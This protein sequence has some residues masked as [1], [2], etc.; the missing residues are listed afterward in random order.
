M[1]MHSL[2][3]FKKIAWRY[4]N[5]KKAF[6]QASSAVK[7]SPYNNIMSGVL[8]NSLTSCNFSQFW[9]SVPVVME[10]TVSNKR[11]DERNESGAK[12]LR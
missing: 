6:P 9:L 4:V 10:R 11:R 8:L 2:V 7:H 5:Y 3:L 1:E 12:F